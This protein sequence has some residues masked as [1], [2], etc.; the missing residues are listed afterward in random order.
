MAGDGFH[1]TPGDLHNGAQR[2]EQFAGEIG[3]GGQ[4]MKQTG[5]EL[6]RSASEDKSG[7]GS[8]IEKSFG[9]ALSVT[10]GVF[11]Q[12][13]RLSHGSSERLHDNATAHSDNEETVTG[14]FTRLHDQPASE[15]SHPTGTGGG[16]GGST[17]PSSEGGATYTPPTRHPTGQS[18][19]SNRPE[20]PSGTSSGLSDRDLDADPVDVV[21]GEVVMTD[22]DV[23]LAGSLPLIL[24]RTH[25]STYRA[26]RSFGPTWSSTVDLR[27]EFDDEGALF[28]AEDGVILVYPHPEP[29]GRVLPVTG[30]A[31]PLETLGDS[32][33]RVTDPDSGRLWEFDAATGLVR[34]IADR[35]GNTI[36][37]LRTDSG[38]PLELHHSGG[39]RVAVATTDD[40]L[41]TEFRLV[42]AGLDDVPIVRFAYAGNRLA[43]VVNS[44]GLPMR[45]EYDDQGRVTRWEDRNG[46]WYS[47]DYRADGRCVRG[48]GTDGYLAASFDYDPAARVTTVTDSTGAVKRYEYD[49]NGKVVRRTDQ[50]GNV[51]L[52][53]WDNRN[54]LLSRTDEAGNTTR[55]E[56]DE[57]G[58]M[59]AVVYPDGNTLT[60]EFNALGQ[61][62]RIAD[63]T[64]AV[65]QRRYDERGNLVTV[66]DP[67][68][69]TTTFHY[70]DVG[71]LMSVQDAVG[72]VTTCETNPAGLPVAIT[73]PSGATV[74]YEWDDFG[75]TS[76]IVDPVGGRTGLGWTVEGKL[77]WR[78]FADGTREARRYD[79]EGNLV[80]HVDALGGRSTFGYT[81]FDRMIWAEEPDGA[82]TRYGYD[83]ELRLSAVT[84]KVGA[85][86]QYE[87]DAAGRL[88][89]EHDFAD[90]TLRYDYDACGRYSATSNGIG[91]TS[92][93]EYDTLGR[94]TRRV[95]GD[96]VTA[97]EY[98]VVGRLV[99]A[100]TPDSDLRFTYDPLG[101]VLSETSNG[102][103][104]SNAYDLLGRRTRRTTPS[105][106]TSTW[107]FDAAGNPRALDVAGRQ[108][109][110]EHDAAG[111]QTTSRFGAVVVEQTWEATHRLRV[112]AVSTTGPN[113]RPLVQR[114][115]Y[116]YR[117]DGYLTGVLDLAQ[118][119]DFTL[120][121]VGRVTATGDEQ[122]AYD[123][124]DNVVSSGGDRFEYAAGRLR[125]AGR[126]TFEH[127]A[128]GRVVVRRSRTLSGQ[129]RVWQYAWDGED[130]L[131]EVVTPD[132]VRWRYGYDAF[133]RRVTKARLTENGEIAERVDFTWDG[134]VLAE[135][136]HVTA[137]WARHKTWDW[138][139]GSN[140]PV[141]Q[142]ERTLPRDTPQDVIDREFYAIITD[143]I[144]TPTELITEAGEIAQRLNSSLWGVSDNVETHLPLRFPGQ[145]HDVESGLHYN[146]FRYYDPAIGRF[147][148]DDPIGLRG[149]TNP[150]AYVPNPTSWADPLGLD[151]CLAA[152]GSGAGQTTSMSGWAQPRPQGISSVDPQ[153]IIALEQQM[154]HPLKNGGAFDQGTLGK[155]YASHAE[156]Q[157]EYLNPGT[158]IRVDKPMCNDCQSYFQALAQHRGQPILVSDPDTHRIFNPDGTVD[159]QPNPH[160][161]NIG[162]I[163]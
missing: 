15:H 93:L 134:T 106:V 88:V 11:S 16:G 91:E 104:L 31:W 122:Y 120:D 54:R 139:P 96:R 158:P 30:A 69:A 56:T 39:Y 10:G 125:T 26:G 52:S 78:E 18:G 121:Q 131:R 148:S 71:H 84:N 153:Q 114:R 161:V 147:Y 49:T 33:Y 123:A 113:G 8:V 55:Y 65:W 43:E 53:T 160:G 67:V 17:E 86:W 13:S 9:K 89:A 159:S 143:L 151:K 3:A 60:A 132:G 119:R 146:V 50:L 141:A 62:T 48:T 80:E 111:R 59:V 92:H 4:K 150:S 68:G 140:R 85:V 127:D 97:M 82:R 1:I 156:R 63:P 149:G 19:S 51:V 101:Q 163:V 136:E 73:D 57:R 27:L 35:N 129:V 109:A 2:L 12:A 135:E 38:V 118:A 22:T 155:Y 112:Q 34:T 25:V 115:S 100:T 23:T 14:S 145:Y 6:V 110:F 157:A 102:R 36:Q 76:A 29:G 45:F 44:S 74:R 108:L 137:Q 152:T 46:F 154:G 87:Y 40:G 162:R 116:Q 79:G 124:N 142:T 5:D 90:R 70:D 21:S 42:R 144:G 103:T 81:A 138:R 75:R 130:R 24:R 47:Y 37:L 99:H 58:N 95:T 66:I 32:G 126:T 107:T 41:I 64:G 61:P 77:T 83:S 94:L 20:E 28:I 105:G 72:Q 133:G 7:V 98:D 117:A 128:N